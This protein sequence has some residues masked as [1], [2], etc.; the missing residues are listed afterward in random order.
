[1]GQS[2]SQQALRIAIV[3]ARFMG[4][5]TSGAPKSPRTSGV[6]GMEQ[7]GNPCRYV[8]G[9]TLDRCIGWKS[10]GF[11]VLTNNWQTRLPKGA[12]RRQRRGQRTHLKA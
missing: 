12:S 10:E 7:L 1:M 11:A 6:N 3:P 9:W 8:A 5:T 2:G 4:P